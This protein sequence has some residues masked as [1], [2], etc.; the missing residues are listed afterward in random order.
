MQTAAYAPKTNH[1]SPGDRKGSIHSSRKRCFAS[2]P[3]AIAGLSRCPT[4][5]PN[6]PCIANP[7]GVGIM[8]MANKAA[9]AAVRHLIQAENAVANNERITSQEKLSVKMALAIYQFSAIQPPPA[10]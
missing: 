5:V 10:R 1:A 4:V 2:E 6:N 8:K 3:K 9:L 7:I